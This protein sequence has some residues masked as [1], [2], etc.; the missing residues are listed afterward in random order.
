[1]LFRLVVVNDDVSVGRSEAFDLVNADGTIP[2]PGT[3]LMIH[4]KMNKF[5]TLHLF[6]VQ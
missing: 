1:M 4:N 3:R 5:Y 2:D 6:E